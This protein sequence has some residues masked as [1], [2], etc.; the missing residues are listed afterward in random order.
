MSQWFLIL[1]HHSFE[2]FSLLVSAGSAAI[3]LEPLQETLFHFVFVVVNLVGWDEF[4]GGFI[5]KVVAECMFNVGMPFNCRW[6]QVLVTLDDHKGI[7]A[8]EL[9]EG[10]PLVGQKVGSASLLPA[11]FALEEAAEALKALVY[12]WSGHHMGWWEPVR[13]QMHSW[14]VFITAIVIV[15]VVLLHVANTEGFHPQVPGEPGEGA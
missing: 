7:V 15:C 4:I 14:I 13:L 6:A 12:D 9:A 8:S 2:E 11:E 3:V 5:I 1:L 10:T